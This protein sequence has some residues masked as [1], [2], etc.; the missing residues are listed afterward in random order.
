MG[1][2]FHMKF[3]RAWISRHVMPEIALALLIFLI[4]ACAAPSALRA[5]D[6]DNQPA[7][8]GSVDEYTREQ[9]PDQ[10][11]DVPE[12]GL[13][14]VDGSCSV[15]GGSSL[16]GISVIRV[17]PDGPAARAGLRD[18]RI[19]GQSILMGVL[20]VGG[21]FFPPALFAAAA[22]SGTDIGVSR[23][24]II[25]VDSERT[26]DVSDLESQI[27]QRRDGPIVYLTVVRAGHREQIR[28]FMSGE[29]D[30]ME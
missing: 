20:G 14:V 5:Q 12:L 19:V 23:D 16:R 27:D 6:N 18:E 26:A 13:E 15:A 1:T 7:E 28:V 24:T 4:L 10:T 25:A 29:A 11:H 9:N 2:A 30:V 17:T 22:L 8:L 3:A 21:L